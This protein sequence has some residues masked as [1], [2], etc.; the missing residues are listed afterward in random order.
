MPVRRGEF[1]ATDNQMDSLVPAAS[2]K[3]FYPPSPVDKTPPPDPSLVLLVNPGPL[4]C[5]LPC[6]LVKHLFESAAWD[7]N[8]LP[9]A[10]RVLAYCICA[11][12][13][14]ISFH[15]TIIGPGPKPESFSDRY[16]LFRGADLR[17]YG[18]RRAPVFRALHERA[19]IVAF[20]TRIHL[21]VSDYST[22]SC[23]VLETLEECES[24]RSSSTGSRL[25]DIA[26]TSSSRPWAVTYMS[27]LRSLAGT[28]TGST[29]ET[30]AL[31][32]GL[33][34]ADASTAILQ[35]K[36][37]LITHADQL[38][39]TG[40]EP[41]SLESI[42]ETL[43]PMAQ[44]AKNAVQ[45]TWTGVR[46]FFFHV[47]R[48]ARELYEKITGDYARRHPIS[49]ASVI[50]FISALTTLRSI[51]SLLFT[52]IDFQVDP[53]PVS[54][55]LSGVRPADR[56]DE[57]VRS[58]IF[59]MSV[60]F[61]SLVLALHR[62]ME[63]RAVADSRDGIQSEWTLARTALLRRQAHSLASD[64]VEDVARTFKLIPYPPQTMH[65]GWNGIRGWAEFCLNEADAAGGIPPARIV[66]FGCLLDTLKALGY[67]R[68]NPELHALIERMDTHAAA[69]ASADSFPTDISAL[70]D[71]TFSLDNTWPGIF[72]M[73]LG[74]GNLI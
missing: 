61:T 20:E 21:E 73:D 65:L 64:A 67:S 6:E 23:F 46:P 36:P 31:W 71:I 40:S 63:Y 26:A 13:S 5:E 1:F 29:D 58:A 39:I 35:R 28:W 41:P 70:S 17:A 22:A 37:V 45:L 3:E 9:P 14:S 25:T 69:S 48:L 18:A 74:D 24:L 62:E 57:A 30:D 47:T 19:L 7:I 8:L 4:S 11:Q 59:G 44:T 10:P 2:K 12:A 49:E 72:S 15:P 55:D 33:L 52:Q 27:H 54:K 43:L 53:N 42:L 56:I 68:N 32:A 66:A 34:M 50:N 51:V 60:G 38:L 16:V